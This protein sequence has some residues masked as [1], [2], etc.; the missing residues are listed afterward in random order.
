MKAVDVNMNQCLI[1][2]QI[3]GL[4]MTLV[5]MVQVTNEANIRRNLIIRTKRWYHIYVGTQGGSYGV[6][7]GH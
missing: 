6:T 7:K 3:Y 4:I 5:L 1:C 2:V